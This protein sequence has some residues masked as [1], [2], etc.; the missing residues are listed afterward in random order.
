MQRLKIRHVTDYSFSQE[1]NPGPHRL[2]LRPRA[3]HDIRIESSTLNITPSHTM[4][5]Q[6]DLYGNSEAWISFFGPTSALHFESEI[7]LQHYES[8]PLDFL[9]QPQAVL[10]PFAIDPNER[11]A[12]IPFLTLCFPNDCIKIRDWLAQFWQPGQIVETYV[13]LDRINKNIAQTLT[14]RMRE[15]PGVQRPSETLA[16]GSGSC[17]DFATL[18]M[19]AARY[20]GLPARFVSGY[21][22]CPQSVIGHGSTHAWCEVY[23]PGAG[24]KSFDSTSGLV[25]GDTHIAVAVSRHPEDIPPVSGSFIGPGGTQSSMWVEVAVTAV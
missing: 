7:I 24:W 9:V 13:L 5:W 18:F 17:R 20:F 4:K 25:V 23:L 1:V 8:A 6:R 10:F 16:R 2:M 15:E 3:G 11:I 19:E 12:L 14:Y 21:L 22:H